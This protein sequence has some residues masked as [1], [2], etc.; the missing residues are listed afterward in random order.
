MGCRWQRASRLL[1]ASAVSLVALAGCGT[2]AKAPVVDRDPRAVGAGARRPASNRLRPS[3]H[4]VVRGDT[5]WAIAWRYGLDY[6]GLARANSIKPPYTIYP[7]QSLR[8]AGIAAPE[9]ESERTRN[10]PVVARPVPRRPGS[11]APA[12]VPSAP[13]NRRAGRPAAVTASSIGSIR[14]QWPASGPS[15]R[16]AAGSGREGIEI[17]GLAGQPVR[18]AAAGKVVYTGDGLV[19]YGRLII[20]QHDEV[21]LSAYAHNRRLLVREGTEVRGGQ[22]IAEMGNTGTREVKLYF[23]IRRDGKPVPPLEY[24]PR[25]RI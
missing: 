17:R 16:A 21:Y 13:L 22:P 9:A 24:L 7:D 25:T 15:S 5:L 2:G 11:A 1:W 8:L 19:G 14:W 12:Q 18:A 20:I 6:R 3:H 23:E 4:R 10:A